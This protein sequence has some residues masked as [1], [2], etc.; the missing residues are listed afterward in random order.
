[1]SFLI[2]LL[3]TCK[4]VLQ[5][6]LFVAKLLKTVEVEALIA[7][8]ILDLVKHKQMRTLNI[9]ITS[10]SQSVLN[11]DLKPTAEPHRY[12]N[13]AVVVWPDRKAN[14]SLKYNNHMDRIKIIPSREGT[15][16][17]GESGSVGA[18]AIP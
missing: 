10:M 3:V 15:E 9:G 2:K 7:Q 18:G 1:M 17:S 8:F 14:C 16:K 6:A 5:S 13:K 12:L 11:F 4:L